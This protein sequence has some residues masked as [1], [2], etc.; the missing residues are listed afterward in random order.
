MDLNSSRPWLVWLLPVQI[1]AGM[2]TGATFGLSLATD[3]L[4]QAGPAGDA[5]AAVGVL[6][7]GVTFLVGTTLAGLSVILQRLRSSRPIDRFSGRFALSLAGGAGV[8]GLSVLE[9]VP[10]SFLGLA[11]QVGL[12]ILLSLPTPVRRVA[13]GQ[14][15]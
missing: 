10:W 3:K 13:H 11:L 12:P 2:A 15:A 5:A 4:S 9:G 14:S 8:G 7:I 6:M 1:G